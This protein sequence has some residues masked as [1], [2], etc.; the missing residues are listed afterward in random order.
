MASFFAWFLDWFVMVESNQ[1][2]DKSLDQNCVAK[3]E[4]S[5]VGFWDL[6]IISRTLWLLISFLTHHDWFWDL[7]SVCFLKNSL[8]TYEHQCFLSTQ[9]MILGR[10][11]LFACF[12]WILLQFMFT[13]TKHICRFKMSWYQ[14]LLIQIKVGQSADSVLKNVMLHRWMFYRVD[15]FLVNLSDC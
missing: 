3:M 6:F 9:L 13:N 14:L 11:Q 10:L 7:F 2:V 5:T 12:Y 8:I 15:Y 4:P 1:G